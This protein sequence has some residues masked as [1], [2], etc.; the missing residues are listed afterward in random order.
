[1]S[2]RIEKVSELLK[3]QLSIMVSRQFLNEYG[4]ITISEVYISKDL[5]E[6]RVYISCFDKKSEKIVLKKLQSWSV[7]FQ[8]ELMQ[9]IVM[10][11]IPKLSFK[12]DQSFESVNRVEEV[13]TNL[14]RQ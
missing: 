9:K 11:F 7:S 5:K 14:K 3:Q 12:I 4:I 8:N 10:K 6:A 2:R 1:M 13:L